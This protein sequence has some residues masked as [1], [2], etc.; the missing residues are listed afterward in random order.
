[1]GD[2]RNMAHAHIP[3]EM[4][5]GMANPIQRMVEIIAKGAFRVWN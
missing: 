4:I 3:E 5:L 2:P 1:M